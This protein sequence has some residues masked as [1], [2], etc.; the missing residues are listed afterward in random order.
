MSRTEVAKIAATLRSV[1]SAQAV[2]T[3]GRTTGL[4]QRLRVVT[5]CA[6]SVGTGQCDGQLCRSNHR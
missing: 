2:N 1:L 3:I 5:P 4:S 6:T